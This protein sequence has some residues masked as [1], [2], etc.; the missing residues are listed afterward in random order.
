MI[1][2]EFLGSPPMFF[3]CWDCDL[4]DCQ[5]FG[6]KLQRK[7]TA[8]EHKCDQLAT[9][10]GHFT[11]MSQ[12]TSSRFAWWCLLQCSTFECP[13]EVVSTQYNPNHKSYTPFPPTWKLL[14]NVW[15][16][17]GFLRCSLLPTNSGSTLNEAASPASKP[18][19]STAPAAGDEALGRWTEWR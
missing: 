16:K 2:P 13:T 6:M 9:A 12:H 19:E 14:R 18:A 5:D 4:S 7:Y 8:H 10:A 3:S 15:K 17:W 1:F 11:M